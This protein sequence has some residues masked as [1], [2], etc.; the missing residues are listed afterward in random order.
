MLPTNNDQYKIFLTEAAF[1]QAH[2]MLEH[3]YTL[4]GLQFRLKIGGKG[5]DGFTY[6]TGFSEKHEDDH[7]LEFNSEQ[8]LILNILVDHLVIMTG[9]RKSIE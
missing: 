6:E 4:E 3:D 8:N 1:M 5:C 9:E 7:V 2:T